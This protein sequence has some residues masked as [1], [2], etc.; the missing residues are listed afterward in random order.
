MYIITSTLYTQGV[1]GFLFCVCLLL[2]FYLTLCMNTL[3]FAVFRGST[4]GL[5]ITK[6]LL[7]FFFFFLVSL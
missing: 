7:Y 2:T 3:L 1:D 5:V 4:L 6:D